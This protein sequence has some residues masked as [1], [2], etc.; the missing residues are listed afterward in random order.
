MPECFYR[1]SIVFKMM[2][3]RQTCTRMFLSSKHAGMNLNCTEEM[4]YLIH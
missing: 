4:W 2:D 3:S 1:A